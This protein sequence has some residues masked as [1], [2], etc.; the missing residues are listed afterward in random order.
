MA[1]II[2]RTTVFPTK[3]KKVG[4][5]EKTKNFLQTFDNIAEL[6][7]FVSLVAKNAQGYV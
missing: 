1:L 5:G 6:S 3:E 7:G 2:Y 4:K